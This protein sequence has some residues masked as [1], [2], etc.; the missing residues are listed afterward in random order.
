[1]RH[2]A[3]AGDQI[4][5]MTAIEIRGP[6]LHFVEALRVEHEPFRERRPLIGKMRFLAD[7]RDR[8]GVPALAQRGR[9]FEASLAGADDDGPGRH[10][11]WEGGTS[12]VR[13]S[14]SSVNLI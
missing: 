14:R 3:I 2:D 8:L 11:R 5:P 10:Y 6:Q 9:G 4:D 7:E 1:D 12:T 13:P